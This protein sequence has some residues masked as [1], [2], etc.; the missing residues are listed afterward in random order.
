LLLAL[1]ANPDFTIFPDG[2]ILPLGNTVVVE[3]IE[4]EADEEVA[5]LV[6]A[7]VLILVLTLPPE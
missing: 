7:L 3:A 2:H 1:Q 4:V 5:V 6:L